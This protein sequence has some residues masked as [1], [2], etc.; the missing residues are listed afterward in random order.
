MLWFKFTLGL[1]FI[2]FCFK[3]IIIHGHTQKQK[4]K[5]KIEPQHIY[6]RKALLEITHK[7]I[8]SKIAKSVRIIYRSRYLWLPAPLS[9]YYT[10]IYPYMSY[11]DIVWSSTY[12]THLNRI[13]LLQKGAIRAFTNSAQSIL[14]TLLHDLPN[15]RF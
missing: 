13:Y 4:T 2:F 9:L 11:F 15:S 6:S 12:N 8:C 3:V 1:N 5:D 14:L 10:L 7:F